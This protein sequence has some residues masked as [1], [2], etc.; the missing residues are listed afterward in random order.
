MKVLFAGSPDVAI[1]T[2]QALQG[3][4]HTVVGVLT[5][6]PAPVG[7]KQVMVPTAVG[8]F[9]TEQGLP[10]RTP[11]TS[12][13]VQDAIDEFSPDVAIVVAYGRI[14][15]RGALELVP[16][17]WW[18]VHFSLLPRWR[19]AAPVQHAILAG[20][21]ETGVTLFRIVEE[22]DAGPVTAAVAHPV[23]AY[24]T[25]GTLLQ[26]LSLVA[27]GLVLDFLDQGNPALAAPTAQI[28]E[29]S[30]APKFPPGFGHLDLRM[31]VAELYRHFRAVT[32]EPGAYVTRQDTGA[33]LKVLSGWVDPDFHP[34][35]PG[36]LLKAPVGILV[37]T[38]SVP[39]VLERVHPAGKKPMAA[40]DWFRG[41]PEGVR[42]DVAGK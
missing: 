38:G 21:T 41:L 11:R 1:P 28:G 37:G 26:K 19:G 40:E 29:P 36:E 13:E 6:P 25:S 32:P 10:V 34:L 20:D 14:L 35:E 9:A 27:P 23:N 33:V 30:F 39:F 3:S 31:D 2:L 42:I 22:L 7:R 17:G 24:D 12:I 15:D 4:G 16:G 18:N 5:Q 8:V